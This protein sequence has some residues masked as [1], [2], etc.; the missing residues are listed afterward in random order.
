MRRGLVWKDD[1]FRNATATLIP[2][3][4][5]RRKSTFCFR[6]W[7]KEFKIDNKEMKMSTS[8]QVVVNDNLVWAPAK[9]SQHANATFRN[10]QL[11]Q[12]AVCVWPPCCDVHVLR[13]IEC[14][15]CWLKFESGQVWANNTQH[16]ATHVH[17]NTE[18]KR[19]QHV[20]PNN[21]SICCVGM[22]RSFGGGGWKLSISTN[23][24][25]Y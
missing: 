15:N 21:G 19:T 20:A 24:M 23:L 13:H 7:L 16:V 18:A 8:L 1:G 10:I 17:R 14:C 6:E 25:G 5:K 9:R 2:E 11:A 4:S 3:K 22:L 12:H